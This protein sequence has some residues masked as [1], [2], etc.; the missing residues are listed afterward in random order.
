MENNRQPDE[1]V[2]HFGDALKYD[3]G[4]SGGLQP[5]PDPLQELEESIPQ[6]VPNDTG[7]RRRADD[8]LP[9]VDTLDALL[10]ESLGAVEAEAR[11]A[12][13]R[14][15]KKRGF[16]GMTREEIEFCNSRM[17]AFEMARQWDADRAVAVFTGFHCTHCDTVQTVFSRLM[18]HHKS[19]FNR[20]TTRW[21]T[22]KETAMPLTTAYEQREVPMCQDC[23]GNAGLVDPLDE[24]VP[25]LEDLINAR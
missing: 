10:A 5:L 19:R 4:Q 1:A 12:K 17:H 20:T 25:W 14:E 6:G 9:E 15:A 7:F 13:D 11:Y 23:L 8:P 24:S 22:V 2:D 18:E 21:V 3:I 16:T